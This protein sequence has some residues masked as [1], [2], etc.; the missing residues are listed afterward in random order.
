M[1]KSNKRNH[2]SLRRRA[3][4]LDPKPRILVACEG[5]VTEP[6]YL[7]YLRHTERIPLTL[8]IESGMTPKSLVER[9][10]TLKAEA[11]RSKDPNEHFDEVWCVFDVDEHP[12]IDGARQQAGENGISLVVSNP[13]FELWL[14]LHFKDH[15]SHIDRK[16]AQSRCRS[17]MPGYNKDPPCK[18]LFTLYEDAMHRAT[19]LAK[20]HEQRNTAGNNPSTNVYE[21]VNTIR[22]HGKQHRPPS[23]SATK[24]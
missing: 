19:A 23:P 9:A 3:P 8:I 4:S 17:H 14:L 21:I 6:R 15:T 7:E 12:K 13:C 1:A 5:K 2:D 24:A 20:W 10:V 18:K 11:N 22:A 16:K